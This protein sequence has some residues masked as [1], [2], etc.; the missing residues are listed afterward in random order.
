MN[1]AQ[2]AWATRKQKAAA[3]AAGPTAAQ[4][5]EMA[6]TLKAAGYRVT[7]PSA[8]AAPKVKAAAAPK[9]NAIGKPYSASYDPN[10]KIRHKV[11]SPARLCKPMPANTP[12][13][14]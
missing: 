6:A 1:A 14:P 5:Q 9:L 11:P 12:Y 10:Y 8:K 2:K 3:L 4:L 7:K 13:V